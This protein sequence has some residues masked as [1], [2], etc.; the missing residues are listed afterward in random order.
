MIYETVCLWSEKTKLHLQTAEE[1]L[2]LDSSLRQEFKG[3]PSITQNGSL[4]NWERVSFIVI[5]WRKL[6]HL[7]DFNNW[8][9]TCITRIAKVKDKTIN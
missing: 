3:S 4:F 9:I 8:L 1:R 7:L 5:Y 6:I 2:N